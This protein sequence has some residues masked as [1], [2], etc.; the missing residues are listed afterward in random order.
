MKR[1]EGPNREKVRKRNDHLVERALALP[2]AQGEPRSHSLPDNS[3]G[4][5]PVPGGVI[6]A[7]M[8]NPTGHFWFIFWICGL[9]GAGKKIGQH[10]LPFNGPFFGVVD[11]RGPEKNWA[12]FPVFQWAILGICGLQ[13]AGKK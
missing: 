5:G 8:P 13:G 1:G 6:F 4:G 2:H 9:Q 3:L 10:F 11:Y 7:F 12:A